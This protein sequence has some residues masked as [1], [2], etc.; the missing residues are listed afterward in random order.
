[1]ETSVG[2]LQCHHALGI[3][4]GE[5]KDGALRFDFEEISPQGQK[6]KVHFF[7]Y[8]Q[9]PDQVRQ[10]HESS[11][12]GGTTW[13]VNYDFTYRRKNRDEGGIKKIW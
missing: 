8:N 10:F 12:D 9:T 6:Q 5:Y 13:T 3:L 11:T 2:G 4:N 7:F 1:M